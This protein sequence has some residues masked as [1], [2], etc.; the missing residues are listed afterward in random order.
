MTE[1]ILELQGIVKNF[2]GIK[3]IDNLTMSL[4]KGQIVALIGPNG[5][6]KTTVF[7]VVTGIYT[8]DQG[9]VL[10][11]GEDITHEKQHVITEKGI[12]RTFQN[13]RLFSGLNVMENVMT[14]YDPHGRYSLLDAVLGLPRKRRTEKQ[15]AE[16]CMRYLELCNVAEHARD[17]PSSLP[18]GLQRKVEIARALATHPKVLCLDE[19]A[20]GLNSAEIEDLIA[21][22][23]TLNE[24]LGGSV[25][26]IEHRMR[27]VMD[28][29]RYI[30]VLNF[31]KLL[32]QGT[33]ADI[34]R[35]S[36]VAHAYIGKEG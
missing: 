35:N 33:P 32:A 7:N 2:G 23:K 34:Q 21:L 22:V 20:A 16:A 5:A 27:V 19:P 36:D 30:Y 4:E 9:K 28:L 13:I 12:A 31:G 29:A 6:G 24:T 3:A 26:L 18:Y 25:L 15:N 17:N 8:A 1:S 10:L 11:D 14:A